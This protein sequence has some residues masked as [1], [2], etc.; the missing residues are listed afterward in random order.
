MIKY[1]LLSDITL[2][3][4]SNVYGIINSAKEQSYT[5][6][7][8]IYTSIKI[9]D[10]SLQPGQTITCNLFCEISNAENFLKPGNIIRL[11]RVKFEENKNKLIAVGFVGFSYLIFCGQYQEKNE[12]YPLSHY[13]QN[14]TFTIYDKERVY[15]LQK[16]LMTVN[17]KSKVPFNKPVCLD[18]LDKNINQYLDINCQIVGRCSLYKGGLILFIWDGTHSTL[19]DRIKKCHLSDVEIKNMQFDGRFK[20]IMNKNKYLIVPV[21]VYDEH[22]E[23]C[24]KFKLRDIVKIANFHVSPIPF[25]INQS[26]E[27]ELPK[28][29]LILHGGGKNFGRG[30]YAFDHDEFLQRLTKV[31]EELLSSNSD[32]IAANIHE[33]MGKEASP[34]QY[35]TPLSSFPELLLKKLKADTSRPIDKMN[36][37]DTLSLSSEILMSQTAKDLCCRDFISKILR[38]DKT[39]QIQFRILTSILYQAKPLIDANI[40]HTQN[41]NDSAIYKHDFKSIKY[42]LEHSSLITNHYR[43]IEEDKKRG[44]IQS[45]N[46]QKQFKTLYSVCCCVHGYTPKADNV[47]TFI[48]VWCSECNYLSRCP[49]NTLH[50][51]AGTIINPAKKTR[52]VKNEQL[53]KYVWEDDLSTDCSE[54]SS[55]LYSLANDSSIP[56]TKSRFKRKKKCRNVKVTNNYQNKPNSLLISID[57]NDL[58]DVDIVSSDDGDLSE[59]YS[60]PLNPSDVEGIDNLNWVEK[61]M[62]FT[63]KDK[64]GYFNCPICRLNQNKR[65]QLEYVYALKLGLADKI[66]NS[67]NAVL[68]KDEALKFFQGVEPIDCLKDPEIFE[69]ISSVLDNELVSP[70]LAKNQSV[71]KT[72]PLIHCQIAFYKTAQYDIYHYIVNTALNNIP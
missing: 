59:Y 26:T 5:S 22:V 50:P 70:L 51:K 31:E 68:W 67:F 34:S 60:A 30:V 11:H 41:I 20:Q 16:F 21:Y 3:Q 62:P 71:P 27:V 18:Q 32:N 24:L 4:K 42:I 37:S 65:N 58:S 15:I 44:V 10:E 28:V 43:K 64:I 14:F 38:L 66:G 49:L 35:Y 48:Q 46:L 56:K 23:S 55:T 7:N 13:P 52:I 36:D 2:N 8:K 61:A 25:S 63:Y 1:T 54:Y 47:L 33:S 57:N 17:I 39:L 6:D 69:S 53:S 9:F 12:I 45:T 19:K 40:N 29:E 72:I